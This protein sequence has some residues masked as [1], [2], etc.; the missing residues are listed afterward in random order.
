[1]KLEIPIQI[2]WDE[3]KLR[4]IVAEYIEKLKEEGWL[5]K[6]ISEIETNERVKENK[7]DGI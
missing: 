6:D 2:T 3:D 1:M 5:Y 4:E 7:G